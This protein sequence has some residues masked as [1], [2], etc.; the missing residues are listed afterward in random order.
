MNTEDLLF[1]LTGLREFL[2]ERG[3]KEL[4]LSMY[5]AKRVR[6]HPRELHALIHGIFSGTNIEIYL[7]IFLYL[8]IG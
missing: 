4:S 7:H 1:S 6:L 2:L 3:V 5:V 8:S